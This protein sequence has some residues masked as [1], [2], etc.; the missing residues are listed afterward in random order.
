MSIK[1]R[2][3]SVLLTHRSTR[4]NSHST[5]SYESSSNHISPTQTNQ[6]KKLKDHDQT[7]MKEAMTTLAFDLT[8]IARQALINKRNDTRQNRLIRLLTIPCRCCRT[9]RTQ[10]RLASIAQRSINIAMNT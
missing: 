8:E 3:C 7:H 5:S 4:E 10:R 2:Y 1:R 9:C 6:R